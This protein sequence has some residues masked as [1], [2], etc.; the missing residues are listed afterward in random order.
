MEQ[1]KYN[2]GIIGNG[3]YIAHINT[4]AEI[5]WLCWPNFDSSPI[6]GNLIDE[7]CGSFSLIPQSKILSHSQSYLEN[8]NILRTDIVTETG[9][10]AVVDFAPRYYKNGVLHYKRNLYRKIIPL[11]GNIKIKILINLTYSYG[12]EILLPKV[13]SNLIQY[14]SSEFKINLLA[15]V[16]VNQIIKG[17]YFQ[18]NQTLYLGLFESAPEEIILN[19]WIESEFTKT[20]SYWQNWVKHCTIPNFAQKQQIR[21]ALCLKLHQFQE[22]GAIIAASTTSL[23]EAPK[24]GRNWDYRFCW[25]RDGFY[26]LLALTNLGQFEELERY[27]QY[28]SN[29]TPTKEGRF[30]PLYSIFGESLLEEKI[31]ELDGYLKNGPVRIGNS[32]YTHKQ[33]DAYGQILLSLLPLYLDERIPEKNRFHN[34]NLVKNILEQIELTMDEPDAGLWEFRN[35]SQK[36]CYTFL[37][38]WIGAKAAREIALQLGQDQIVN[39]TEILMKKAEKNIEACYDEELGCYTQAQGKKDLDASLLQLITL[40]YLDP[41][42]EKAKSHIKAIENSLKSKN[43]FMYRYLHQD[44]FGTP[45]TTF[46]VCTFWY[47]EALACMDRV[48]EAI[49]LFDYVCE[50]S[51]QLGLFS[52]DLESKTGGQWG[53]FPQTYSHVGLVNAAQ[54]ISEKK[55]KSLFW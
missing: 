6:F 49:A 55:S 17:N 37:F 47:I 14:E 20:K 33:N 15:N 25:L 53:N 26:T 27:S 3:S 43:G 44:D 41:K 48:N 52:E 22:T 18:L 21:S 12:N 9:S 54:K 11:D 50:H 19:E 5:V 13:T 32:A 2:L 10:F 31:L 42:T 7:R 24:S 45:E 16:S 1:H 40:G 28:I 8:T 29:L 35:F 23:P 51:N 30:Q 38:H 34:L 46:L 36:H 4:K 39:K